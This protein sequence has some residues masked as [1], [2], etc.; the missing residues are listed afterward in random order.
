MLMLIVMVMLMLN[1]AVHKVTTKHKRFMSRRGPFVLEV[2]NEAAGRQTVK[3]SR[4]DISGL[5][6][7]YH[8][9][10]NIMFEAILWFS[11]HMTIETSEAANQSRIVNKSSAQLIGKPA[12]LR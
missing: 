3:C 11:D 7:E 12:T 2:I 1:L 5:C 10:D 8:P 4:T 9:L 6:W